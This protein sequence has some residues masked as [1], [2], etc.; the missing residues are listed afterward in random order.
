MSNF[1]A[2]TEWVGQPEHDIKSWCILTWKVC[3]S[4]HSKRVLVVLNMVWKVLEIQ[5]HHL[6]HRH[7]GLLQKQWL[8]CITISQSLDIIK[9]HKGCS[10]DILHHSFC[11]SIVYQDVQKLLLTRVPHQPV[12]GKTL[13]GQDA[14]GAQ[15][16]GHIL[17]HSSHWWGRQNDG[18]LWL[19][20][21]ERTP[22]GDY[23]SRGSWVLLLYNLTIAYNTV[24]WTIFF[25]SG[26]DFAPKKIL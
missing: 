21:L 2:L 10:I 16:W 22:H 4:W 6:Q 9:G 13:L 7:P 14:L 26:S 1:L 12:L 20:I 24:G 15:T 17:F 25:Q 3:L 8:S 23:W 18:H 5:R 19:P 11:I